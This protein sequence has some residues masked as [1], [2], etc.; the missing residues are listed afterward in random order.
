M[1]REKE[2]AEQRRFSTARE[3]QQQPSDEPRVD[4]VKA[5]AHEVECERAQRHDFPEP[6]RRRGA[7]RATAA[8]APHIV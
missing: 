3:A 2:G 8:M 6:K 1:Q 5:D 4:D 7:C